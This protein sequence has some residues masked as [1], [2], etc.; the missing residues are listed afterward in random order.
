MRKQTNGFGQTLVMLKLRSN[1][2]I[3]VKTKITIARMIYL[4]SNY[5]SGKL[6]H[7]LSK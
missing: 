7:V 3:V 2:L 6:I 5:F 1:P 4:V